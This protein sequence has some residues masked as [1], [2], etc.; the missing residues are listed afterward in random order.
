MPDFFEIIIFLIWPII[1]LGLIIG[2]FVYIFRRK[3]KKKLEHNKDWYLMPF[4]SKEDFVTQSFFVL[5]LLFLTMTLFAFNRDFSDIVEWETIILIVSVIGIGGAY[6]YK[7]LYSLVFSVLGLVMW[8]G[9]RASNWIDLPKGDIKISAVVISLIF[10]ALILYL[11]GRI[12]EK[13]IRYKRFAIMYSLIGIVFVNFSLFVLST[14]G[15]LEILKEMTSGEMFT[16]SWQLSISILIFIISLIALAVYTL[17]KKLVFIPEIVVWALTAFLFGFLMFL[18]EQND[19]FITAYSYNSDLTVTGFMWAFVFNIIL[20]LELV[21]LIL[22]GYIKRESW[23]IN[24]GAFFV[25]LFILIKYFDWF[26]DFMEKSVF[27]IG[28]GVLLFLL[29]WFME[30]GRRYVLSNIKEETKK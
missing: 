20:F 17:N 10:I 24:L 18:P 4:F 1:I 5:T 12:H 11:I 23:L 26:F 7:L 6:Y 21:G 15:G 3:R 2:T 25:F 19:L 13:E 9:V 8:W 27:F 30:R 29:G 22:L 28:A 14:R 16:S